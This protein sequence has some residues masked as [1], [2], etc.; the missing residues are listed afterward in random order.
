[1]VRRFRGIVAPMRVALVL[2]TLLGSTSVLAQPDPQPEEPPPAAKLFIEGRAALDAGDA[3]LACKKFEESFKLDATAAGTMLNL[4]LCHEQLGKLATA[5][6]WFRRAQARASENQLTETESVAKEKS[7]LLATKVGILK[8]AVSSNQGKPAITLD[9]VPVQEVDYSRL[10]VDGGRH[11]VDATLA[12]ATSIH[13]EVEVT[14]GRTLEIEVKLFVP[15]AEKKYELVDRGKAQRRRAYIF[16]ATGATLLIGAGVIGF[17]G[18]QEHDQAELPEDLRHWKN[19][20]RYGAT[21]LFLVGG[22]ALAYGIVL[23]VKAPG[24]E[25]REVITPLIGADRVGIGFAKQF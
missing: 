17:V 23:R 14:D 1:V 22:A 20:V 13:R 8:L 9:G 18:R 25:R 6:K 11:L 16:G 10:E 7:A 19:V 4:G 21:P 3:T 15:P 5:L 24:K 2:V 12:G